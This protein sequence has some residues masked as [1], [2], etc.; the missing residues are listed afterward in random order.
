VRFDFGGYPLDAGPRE[1]RRRPDRTGIEPQ[2]FDLP[3]YLIE[4]CD[5]VVT[6]DD[7]I[8]SVWGGRVAPESALTGR[9]TAARKSIGDAADAKKPGASCPGLSARTGEPA[10]AL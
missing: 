5:R 6:K 7:L 9:I 10:F 1:L 3:V 8:A 2:A 4:N